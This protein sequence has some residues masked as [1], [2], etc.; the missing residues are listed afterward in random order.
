MQRKSP[1]SDAKRRPRPDMTG[2][3]RS[4]FGFRR[5]SIASQG[6]GFLFLYGSTLLNQNSLLSTHQQIINNS[7]TRH[8]SSSMNAWRE[9]IGPEATIGSPVNDSKRR[10]EWVEEDTEEALSA[11]LTA[12]KK[13]LVRPKKLRRPDD[14]MSDLATPGAGPSQPRTRSRSPSPLLTSSKAEVDS[15]P[16]APARPV[17]PPPPK[18]LP[19][20]R[21]IPLRSYH[22]PLVSCRSVYNYTR[23]NHIEEGTYGVVFRARCN[24]TGGI[25]ALKKLKLEEEKAGFPITSLREVMALMVAGSHENVVGLREIVVGD[26]LNQCVSD[27]RL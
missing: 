11:K 14:G 2:N 5:N 12:I 25:Y 26:T 24:D 9:E 13:R 6:G 21:L 18:R 8:H 1:L 23:L 19:R 27:V 15:K 3:N 10:S 22:P 4:N 20:S 17:S 7:I 16:A